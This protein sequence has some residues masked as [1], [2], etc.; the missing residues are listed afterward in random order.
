MINVVQFKIN[1][2]T[3]MILSVVITNKMQYR[4]GAGTRPSLLENFFPAKVNERPRMST[5]IWFLPMIGD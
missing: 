5:Q 4:G 2:T 3:E 1:R